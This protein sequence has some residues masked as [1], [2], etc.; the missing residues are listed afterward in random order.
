MEGMQSG[1][2][3]HGDEREA[4]NVSWVLHGGPHLLLLPSPSSTPSPADFRLV[5]FLYFLAVK[6]RAAERKL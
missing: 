3:T 2:N 6:A 5:C 1:G 4:V